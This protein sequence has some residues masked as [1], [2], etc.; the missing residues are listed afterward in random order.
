MMQTTQRQTSPLEERVVEQR[1][2]EQ[3][4]VGAK[5]GLWRQIVEGERKICPKKKPMVTVDSQGPRRPMVT[6]GW[7]GKK[8]PMVA[9]GWKG[10]K[11]PIDWAERMNSMGRA[12]FAENFPYQKK[13]HLWADG[14]RRERKKRPVRW[15][16]EQ[17]QR[18][19][20]E[21]QRDGK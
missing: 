20:H 16:S 13:A 21:T 17:E 2:V 18:T 15:I 6:V 9:V 11:R 1:V 4:V 19:A 12:G 8:K 14:I 10:K 3:R 7:K 5:L